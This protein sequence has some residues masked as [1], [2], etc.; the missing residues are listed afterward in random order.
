MR[1]PFCFAIPTASVTLY[2][3]ASEHEQRR[4]SSK[5]VAASRVKIG[6]RDQ[7]DTQIPRTERHGVPRTPTLQLQLKKLC[8]VNIL[9]N[10]HTTTT[11]WARTS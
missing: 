7:S 8:L 10:R 9:V 3:R 1:T 2:E 6:S 11:P 4:Q 5:A